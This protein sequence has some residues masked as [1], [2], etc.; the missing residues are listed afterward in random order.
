VLKITTDNE[1][2]EF[3]TVNLCGRFTGE[4]VPEV[5]KELSR[6]STRWKKLALDLAKV[7][8]VDREAIMFLCAVRS[9]NIAIQNTP[10]YVGLWMEQ[11]DCKGPPHS[12]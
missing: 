7:T 1:N 6:T 5:E 11:E 8:F 10:L 9:R 12:D 2:P 3:I 4:Y